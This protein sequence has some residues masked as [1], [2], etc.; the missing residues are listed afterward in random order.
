MKNILLTGAAGF[1]GSH[2][3]DRLVTMGLKVRVLSHYNSRHDLGNLNLLDPSVF[4]EL[5]II[6]G[7][8]M[9]TDG[10]RSAMKGCDTVFH[11]GALIGIPYSYQNPNHVFLTNTQGTLNVLLAARDLG[12]ERIVH[13]STSEVYGTA[14]IIPINEEH[15]LQAQSPYSA[16]KIAADKIAESFYC[17]FNT[18]VVTVRPFNTYGPRQSARA[19]I[20]TII[21]QALAGGEIKLGMLDSRRDFTY[22][23][24]TV[25]GFILAAQ[26]AGVEGN[27]FNLGVGEDNT[28]GEIADMI[29]K[30]VKEKKGGTF[31]AKIQQD[32]NRLRPQRSEVMRLISD[33]SKAKRLLNWQP[34]ITL[35]QGLRQTVQWIENNPQ[36]FRAGVYEV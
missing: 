19:V 32:N 21:S 9:D 11:L 24:D 18:P 22:V 17:S 6:T 12:T 16:S 2:L 1:I 31:E 35:E 29:F 26:T 36:F 3:A 14:R 5:E 7:D 25:N 13:T 10:V 28:V 30:I 23:N 4:S 33:N 20:P 15:P 34:Q 27:V 8:L